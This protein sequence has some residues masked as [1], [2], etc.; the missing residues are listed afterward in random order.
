MA[1]KLTLVRRLISEAGLDEEL[2]N[3]INNP[4]DL[5][6]RQR[7]M[8]STIEQAWA[9]IQLARDDWEWRRG[10]TNYKVWPRLSVTAGL[11]EGIV[12]YYDTEGLTAAQTVLALY[13]RTGNGNNLVPSAVSGQISNPLLFYAAPPGSSLLGFRVANTTDYFEGAASTKLSFNGGPCSVVIRHVAQKGT[14]VGVF[15]YTKGSS[16]AN[17]EYGLHV[18]TTAASNDIVVTSIF[19][20][21]KGSITIPAGD[22]ATTPVGMCIT[23]DY[24]PSLSRCTLTVHAYNFED[25]SLSREYTL[26]YNVDSVSTPTTSPLRLF[27]PQIGT[28]VLGLSHSYSDSQAV[29]FFGVWNRLLTAKERDF[30]NTYPRFY[31]QLTKSLRTKTFNRDVEDA[32]IGS[33]TGEI[34]GQSSGTVYQVAGTWPNCS[35]KTSIIDITQSASNEALPITSRFKIG[36]VFE[37]DNAVEIE[38]IDYATYKPQCPLSNPDV[39]V[40][41]DLDHVWYNTVK[42]GTPA[43]ATDGEPNQRPLCYVKWKDFITNRHVY[44]PATPNYPKYV[45]E[46]PDGRLQLIPHPDRT[47]VL[48]FTYTKTLDPFNLP[49]DDT[50]VPQ[51]LPEKYHDAI[52]WKAVQYVGEADH[53]AWQQQRGA[54]RFQDFLVRMD[55]SD[56]NE[57]TFSSARLY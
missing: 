13:D 16:T 57:M 48:S 28:T 35:G 24:V 29:G 36:E 45:T 1:S 17:V 4:N 23:Q 9:D 8:K 47:Y 11:S 20:S 52:L 41:T 10:Y 44:G 19:S 30:L 6:P 7:R 33:V 51:G 21:E 39:Q 14:D 54:K 50:A 34:E 2:P 22:F 25:P 53:D 18:A 5:T 40:V 12:A 15:L 49:D 43:S 37:D 3:S 31:S 38:A 27:R 56:L 42:I 26:S 46:T 32:I 55:S